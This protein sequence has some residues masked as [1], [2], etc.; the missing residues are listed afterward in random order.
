MDHHADKVQ[1]VQWHPTE[2]TVLL[3][4]SYNK[5][6][7]VTDVRSQNTGKTCDLSADSECIQWNVHSS[8]YFMASTEDGLVTCYDVRALDKPVWTL[9][10]HGKPVSGLSYNQ[11]VPNLLATASSDKSVKFYDISEQKPKLIYSQ[12]VTYP[13]F[14]LSWYNDAA[15]PFLLAA[16][17]EGENTEDEENGRLTVW[18]AKKFDNVA[19]VFVK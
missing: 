10:A 12:R 8:Q 16:G 17:G 18:D 19:K 5:T 11:C 14:S 13:I 9:S 15:Y 1:C 4:G 2:A 6:A 3:S 7:R